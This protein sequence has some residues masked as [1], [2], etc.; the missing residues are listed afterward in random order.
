MILVTR[1]KDTVTKEMIHHS[2]LGRAS[3]KFSIYSENRG[4]LP[5]S[6]FTLTS[7]TTV[8][9]LL[10]VTEEEAKQASITFAS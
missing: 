9:L 6:A 2:V 3:T 1:R 10:T 8:S 7:L 4:L 5:I